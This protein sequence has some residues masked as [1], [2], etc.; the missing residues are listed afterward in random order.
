[1]S[2][3]EPERVVVRIPHMDNTVSGEIAAD[4]AP[5]SGFYGW[6]ELLDR[7]ERA[8]EGGPPG[9]VVEPGGEPGPVR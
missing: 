2:A 7:L 6:L 4:G 8:A 1:M 5:P 9:S 3:G